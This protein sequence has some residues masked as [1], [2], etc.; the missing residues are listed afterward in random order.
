MV[1]PSLLASV[2]DVTHP[3]W[4]AT[5]LGVYRFWRDIGYAMGAL[6]AGVVAAW[7]GLIWAVHVAGIITFIS[8][9]IVWR[10]MKE[11]MNTS[12]VKI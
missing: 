2:S 4:R 9:L 11:T 3:T 8:G 1:Y 10:T 6:M 5:S 7:L 12:V